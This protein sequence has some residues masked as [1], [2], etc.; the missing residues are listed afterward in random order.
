MQY[1]KFILPKTV[2]IAGRKFTISRLGAAGEAQGVYNVVAASVKEHGVIG[3]SILP[4]PVVKTI[5]ARTAVEVNDGTHIELDTDK[6][7]EETFKEDFDSLQNLVIQMIKEN[8]DF[9]VS[10]RLLDLLGVGEP[11]TE[12]GS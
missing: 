1:D 3:I 9:F 7:I 2:E 4:W 10:G 11:G 5:L 8:F 6:A 12:S